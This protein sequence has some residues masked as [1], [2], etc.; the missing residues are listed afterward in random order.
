MLNTDQ[1]FGVIQASPC[2]FPRNNTNHHKERNSFLI[3][4]IDKNHKVFSTD[5]G[6]L[7]TTYLTECAPYSR[8]KI[9]R[10]Y[11]RRI[12]LNEVLCIVF[13]NQSC[14]Y[15]SLAL[16]VTQFNFHVQLIFILRGVRLLK[17][18]CYIEIPAI[19]IEI[20]IL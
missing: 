19:L 13:I 1:S 9:Y 14:N 7:V 16:H 17:I 3:I 6:S 20:Y 10:I 5:F 18:L 15:M 2:A 12:L 4:F 8:L 11:L